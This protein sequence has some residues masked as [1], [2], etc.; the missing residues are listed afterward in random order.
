MTGGAGFIGNHLLDGLARSGYSV[1]V[2]DDLPVEAW[3]T[4]PCMSRTLL[5]EREDSSR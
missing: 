4:S 1:K 3:K 2:L 5:H